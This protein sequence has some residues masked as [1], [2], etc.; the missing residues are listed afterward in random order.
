VDTAPGDPLGHYI[1][2][3]RSEGFFVVAQFQAQSATA[4]ETL[5]LL[6][7][8][9]SG[10]LLTL[11]TDDSQ[12]VDAML[13]FNVHTEDARFL[14][15]AFPEH[16]DLESGTAYIRQSV[17]DGL[18][19]QCRR[20]WETHA[21]V[22]EWKVTPTIFLLTPSEWE[23]DAVDATPDTLNDQRIGSLPEPVRHQFG[24]WSR[25]DARRNDA[26]RSHDSDSS[27]ADD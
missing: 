13:H 6:S 4:N 15:G 2:V 12:V 18:R 8:P 19:A 22:R 23:L 25:S 10:L 17:V 5:C 20:L 11:V 24:L 7:E 21:L 1:E 27:A 3:A 14:A 16:R 26:T 9:F